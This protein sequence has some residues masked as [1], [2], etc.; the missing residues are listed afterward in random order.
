MRLE[1][2]SEFETK[3]K[4]AQKITVENFS[5]SKLLQTHAIDY[6]FW[7][8]LLHSLEAIEA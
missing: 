4:S 3:R 6:N 2:K 1:S 7:Y 8:I 5:K